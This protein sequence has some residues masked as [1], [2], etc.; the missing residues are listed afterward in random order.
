MTV[1]V[2]NINIDTFLLINSI[3]SGDLQMLTYVFND[4]KVS[5]HF[6]LNESLVKKKIIF[7]SEN[8]CCKKNVI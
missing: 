1:I 7:H 8:V 2:C 4:C 5:K 6:S 3:K